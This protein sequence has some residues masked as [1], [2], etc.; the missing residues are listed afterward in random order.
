LTHATAYGIIVQM[1]V[2]LDTNVLVSGLVRQR[3]SA[4]N[5]VVRSMGKHWDLA[6]TPSIFLEYEE[7][8]T[9]P[10][11]RKLTRLT[12]N[13]TAT[14]LDYLVIIGLQ[15]A[16][17]YSWRPNLLDE[18]DNKFIDCAVSAD[19]DYLITGNTKHFRSM[20]LGPFDF[21]MISPSAFV[22]RTGIS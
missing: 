22:K 9:R 16:V 15:T 5:T 2:V 7:V 20:E 11:I 21:E 12:A 8:L 19:V 18:R 3:S 10:N 14:V 1:R 4:T 13:E 6:I 17:Y